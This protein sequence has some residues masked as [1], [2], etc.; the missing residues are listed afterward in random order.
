MSRIGTFV[1]L[2]FEEFHA[3]LNAWGYLLDFS[4]REHSRWEDDPPLVRL[5]YEFDPRRPPLPP[6]PTGRTR[7]HP[8]TGPSNPP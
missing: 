8:P 1:S 2:R 3:L 6:A 5:R 7:S 4:G